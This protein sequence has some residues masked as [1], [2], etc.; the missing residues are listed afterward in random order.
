MNTG[1]SEGHSN[2]WVMGLPKWQSD[3][4]CPWCLEQDQ[5]FTTEI[6][7]SPEKMLLA[8]NGCMG[9]RGKKKL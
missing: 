3:L 6:D 9:R 2:G 7:F 5:Q 4:S 8:E 1:D